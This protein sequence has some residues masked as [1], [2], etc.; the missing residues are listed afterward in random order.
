M[1]LGKRYAEFTLG[2]FQR[3]RVAAHRADARDADAELGCFG[4]D[5]VRVR[6]GGGEDNATLRLAEE[7]RVEECLHV[8]ADQS[9][10]A[11][12][13]DRLSD[14]GRAIVENAGRIEQLTQELQRQVAAWR[15]IEDK[16]LAID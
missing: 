10:G 1:Q 13:I 5:F 14:E 2:H 8:G 9:V 15:A 3:Q 16:Y 11:R 7:H 12:G 6:G 4:E